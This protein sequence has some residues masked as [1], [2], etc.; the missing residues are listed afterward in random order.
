[1]NFLSCFFSNF[2]KIFCSNFSCIYSIVNEIFF[3]EATWEENEDETSSDGPFDVVQRFE[4]DLNDE[5]LLADYFMDS[6]FSTTFFSG[7]IS[8]IYLINLGS[9]MGAT[10]SYIDI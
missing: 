4:L 5:E 2:L 1:M 9:S 6:D 3:G 10:F 8:E 7:G